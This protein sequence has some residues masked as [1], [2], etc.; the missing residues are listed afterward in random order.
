MA[1]VGKLSARKVETAKPGTKIGDGGGLWL[2][3]VSTGARYWSFRY[4][5]RG[6]RPREMGLGSASDVSLAEAREAAR[7]CRRLIRAG[8]DPMKHRDAEKAE[9]RGMSFADVAALYIEAHA[10]SW[11]NLRHRR[12]WGATLRQYVFPKIGSLGVNQIGV[13]DVLAI[14]EPV[15]RAK[16]ETASRVRGRI[17]S[18]LDYAA[19]RR[20]RTGDNVARWSG[21]LD[22]LLPERSKVRSVKPHA[23]LPWRELPEFWVELGKQPGVAARAL[24]FTILTAS[25][26]GETIG[27]TWQEIDSGARTWTI[28]EA[29]MKAGKRHVVPLSDAAMAILSEMVR[30]RRKDSDPVFQSP[31][32]RQ[33]LSNMAMAAVLKRMRRPDLTVHGFRS[34][35]TDWV[36][37]ATSYDYAVREMA[38]AHTIESKVERAYR[39]GELIEKRTRLMRDWAAY[40]EGRS[41][42]EGEV[43]PIRAKGA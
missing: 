12:Q 27:A 18:V 40:A 17:E 22:Q 38:L 30:D 35:F 19:A 41:L 10:D 39:R 4:K 42:P 8:I 33:P 15:W 23:A 26:T 9:Q 14:L 11:R 31:R 1:V 6:G 43:V 24:A 16:P 34:C 37:E 28:D 7:E 29:R 2:M 3:T 13:G 20:W 32:G 21:H 5:L 25:R 36:S